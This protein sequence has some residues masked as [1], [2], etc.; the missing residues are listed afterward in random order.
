M[1]LAACAVCALIV[2]VSSTALAEVHGGIQCADFSRKP[3]DFG[4]FV[5]SIEGEIDAAAVE[6]VRKLF[7][8]YHTYE[9]NPGTCEVNGVR[10]E[11]N[12]PGG[13]VASAMEI[14]RILRKERAHLFVADGGVCVSACVLVLA[15]AVERY[16]GEGT[17]GIHR[18]FVETSPEHQVSADQVKAEYPRMLTDLRAYLREMN[19]SERL[20]DDMLAVDPEEVRVLT[21]A[22]LRSRPAWHRPRG[23]AGARRRNR[24]A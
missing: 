1:R 20:A 24:G 16:A 21:K 6:K 10:Y 14:G 9:R 3:I 18:P 17:V 2:L 5:I 7:A 15:G 23:A 13:D 22:E 8:D 4:S 11:I 19:V 12:S